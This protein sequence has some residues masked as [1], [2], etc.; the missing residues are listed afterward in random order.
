MNLEFIM[1]QTLTKGRQTY[2]IDEPSY[3]ETK[4]QGYYGSNAYVVG[5]FTARTIIIHYL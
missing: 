1:A 5:I 3:E 2:M 4:K